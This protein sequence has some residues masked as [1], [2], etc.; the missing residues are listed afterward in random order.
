[1]KSI[2]QASM[3]YQMTFCSD[4]SGGIARELPGRKAGENQRQLIDPDSRL[5]C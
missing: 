4:L 1:V 2:F 3:L 5:H